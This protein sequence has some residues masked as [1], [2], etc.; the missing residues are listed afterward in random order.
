MGSPPYIFDLNAPLLQLSPRDA[1]RLRDACEG[2]AI[3]GGTGSGK[4]SGSGRALARAFLRAG[5]GGIVLCAKQDEER[6]R[7]RSYVRET[8]RAR[9]LIVF[10]ASGTRRF[11]FLE[12]EMARARDAGT[13]DIGNIVLLFMRI[14]DAASA[15]G[16]KKQDREPFWRDAVRGMLKNAILALWHGRGRVRLSEIMRMVDTGPSSAQQLH[17]REWRQASFHYETLRLMMDEP[18]HPIAREEAEEV[19]MYWPRLFT[20]YGEKTTGGIVATLATM[21]DPFL[22]GKMRELFTTSTNIVPEMTHQGAIILIDLP[23]KQWHEAGL[24][25]QHIFKFLW[26]RATESRPVTPTTRPVFLWADECQFFASEYDNEFQSTARRSVACSVYLTQ[27]LSGLYHHI[28]AEKPEHAAENLLGNFQTKIF[29]GNTNTPTN[30]WAAEMIG[31]TV[32]WRRNVGENEGHSESTGSSY[33]ESRSESRGINVGITDGGGE[34]SGSSSSSSNMNYTSSGS[35]GTSTSW[36]RSEGSNRSLSGGITTGTNENRSINTGRS[37]GASEVIDYQL[38]PNAFTMLRSGGEEHG[39]IVD[40]IVVKAKRW[41]HSGSVW[42]PCE[43][44]QD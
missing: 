5:F 1:W 4:S 14:A 21:V 40:G 42:L 24:I 39:F 13:F 41:K 37:Q 19:A 22:T 11:N 27:N 6:E 7:W 16:G 32:Q 8:G 25:A 12:Y 31:K 28:P 43:F 23:V 34:N 9:S 35:S 44:P 18:V 26:Q 38:Q 10:D 20:R 33:G 17:D 2:T 15:S 36:G 30:T 29:H 3:F